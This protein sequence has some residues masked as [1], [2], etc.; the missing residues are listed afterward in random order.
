M[1][2]DVIREWRLIQVCLLIFVVVLCLVVLACKT[3][4][5]EQAEPQA[6]EEVPAPY[7]YNIWYVPS[8]AGC[9]QERDCTCGYCPPYQPE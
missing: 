4:E 2:S 5:K 7:S 3:P 8:W 9:T 6:Q 1:A